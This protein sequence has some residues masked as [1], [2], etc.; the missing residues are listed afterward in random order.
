MAQRPVKTSIC[1]QWSE[2]ILAQVGF[3]KKHKHGFYK[4]F[5][6]KYYEMKL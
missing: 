5:Y 1:F 4:F 3:R 6:F 2:N